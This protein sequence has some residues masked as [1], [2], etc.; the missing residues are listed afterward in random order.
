MCGCVIKFRVIATNKKPISQSSHSVNLITMYACHLHKTHNQQKSP[1]SMETGLSHNRNE[2]FFHVL[3]Q[4]VEAENVKMTIFSIC[5]PNTDCHLSNCHCWLWTK[6]LCV[7]C[8]INIGILYI[9]NNK[10]A[11]ATSFTDLHTIRL[12]HSHKRLWL[13]SWTEIQYLCL[14]VQ[15][16]NTS[17]TTKF[18]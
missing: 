1:S 8:V 3:F 10:N 6:Q 17:L 13:P 14:I 2:K 9:F 16:Y 15:Y 5:S 18:S 4:K 7:V 11:K 12:P